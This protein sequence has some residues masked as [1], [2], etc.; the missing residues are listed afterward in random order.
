MP[1]LVSFNLDPQLYIQSSPQ[2]AGIS[3]VATNPS[4]HFDVEEDL[5]R[6]NKITY[7]RSIK[8]EGVYEVKFEIAQGDSLDE[9]LRIGTL[10]NQSN[11]PTRFISNLFSDR[12]D[13]KGIQVYL[14]LNENQYPLFDGSTFEEIEFQLDTA[15][16]KEIE[17]LIKSDMRLNHAIETRIEL[18]GISSK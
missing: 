15:A 9:T 14:K 16:Q 10:V 12:V 8:D 5:Y 3:E 4:V 1:L 13:L 6:S 2:V 7:V 11:A 18:R 17:I